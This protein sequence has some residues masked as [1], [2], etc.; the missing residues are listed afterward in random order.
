MILI[1]VFDTYAG[2]I[3]IENQDEN[4]MAVLDETMD[5]TIDVSDEERSPQRLKLVMKIF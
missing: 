3:E 2:V 4:E 5:E 1:Y